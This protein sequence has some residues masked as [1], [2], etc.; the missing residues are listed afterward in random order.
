MAGHKIDENELKQNGRKSKYNIEI[1]AAEQQKELNPFFGAIQYLAKPLPK[2]W[3]RLTHSKK[4][5]EM[6]KG[7]KRRLY[8]NKTEAN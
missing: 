2:F 3:K 6:G 5:M 7:P 1:E 4:T 8:A